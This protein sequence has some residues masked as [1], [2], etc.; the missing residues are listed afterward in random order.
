MNEASS[1]LITG[2][3]GFV[4]RNLFLRALKEGGFSK[5]YLPVRNPKKFSDLWDLEKLGSLP[6]HVKVFQADT[7]NWNLGEAAAATHVVHSAGSIFARDW[8]EYY[9]TNVI[10]TLNLL[11]ELKNPSRVIL[12]SS[13]AAAGPCDGD[14]VKCE[15]SQDS[16]VTWYGKSKLEMEKEVTKNYPQWSIDFLRPPMIFGARDQ[17]TLPLFKMVQKPIQFKPGFKMKTYSFVDVE[18]LV[19]AIEL[20]L[21]KKSEAG[22]HTYYATHTQIITDKDL[23]GTAAQVSGKNSRIIPLP[24]ALLK[25]VSRVVDNIPTARATIPSLSADRAKEIW[26]WRWVASSEKLSRDTGWKPKTDLKASLA[27]TFEWYQQTNQL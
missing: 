4:G 1:L 24:Q 27:Q 15:T 19:D 14:Q 5:I 9:Q 16:P 6:S 3:T 10:G 12:L 8:K 13:L 2:V 26:A 21:K 22:M 23:I 20:L 17:A 11:K 18:D 7:E 25:I